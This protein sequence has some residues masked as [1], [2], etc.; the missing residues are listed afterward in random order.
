MATMWCRIGTARCTGCL[1]VL[2]LLHV[3]QICRAFTSL[4]NW[5]PPYGGHPVRHRSKQHLQPFWRCP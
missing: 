3:L 1:G 4:K 5:W 2:P